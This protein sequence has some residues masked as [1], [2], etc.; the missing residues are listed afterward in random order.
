MPG[1]L[2]AWSRGLKLV[3]LAV[4]A[5]LLHL[6]V[7]IGLTIR[8]LI[9]G[10][11]TS[12]LQWTEYLLLV[13]AG[14]MLALAIGVVGAIPELARARVD[15]RGLVIAAAGFGV[16]A[17]VVGWSYH[18]LSRFFAV[19]SDPDSTLADVGLASSSI[20]SLKYVTIVRDLGYA[21]A[22]IATIRTV[23][24]AA[25]IND[26]LALRDAAG[27]MAR[28]L[29]AMLVADVFY[30]LTYGLGG[31]VGLLGLLG[32]LLVLAYWIY[33]HFRLARFLFD[34]AYFVNEPHNLLVA[35]VVRG[36]AASAPAPA[37]APVI[38]VAPPPPPSPPVVAERPGDADTEEPRLL[39]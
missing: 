26:Q 3:R 27:S 30:Q 5:M 16:A 23:Q 37:P 12:F 1:S 33:C 34:A 13:N 36:T 31:S 29:I 32:S 17:L 2:P 39:R 22:L 11:S 24:R 28:A 4:L 19:M 20:Q 25:A 38:A 18:V 14:A 8:F 10:A 21:I 7:A 35:T 15:I 9:G 6:V